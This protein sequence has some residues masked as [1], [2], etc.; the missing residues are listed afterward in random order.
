[1]TLDFGRCRLSLAV[2]EDFAYAG[3]GVTAGRRIA[4]TLSAHAA[5]LPG[6]AWHHGRDRD[7]VRRGRDRATARPRR[8][9]LRPG[10][11]RQHAAANHLREVET[12]L[13]SQAVLIRT[14]VPVAAQKLDWIDRLLKRIDGVQQVRESKYIMLHAP[15]S[16]LAEITQPAAR[17]RA[18]DHHPARGHGREGRGARRLP[19]ERV[20]GDA[21]EPE[22]RRRVCDPGPAGREDAGMNATSLSDLRLE[23]L[24]APSARGTAAPA[25][26]A[27]PAGDCWTASATIIDAGSRATVTPR[28]S[29]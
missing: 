23:P 24:D 20:L 25:G 11:D 13:E 6:D 27:R 28:C 18:P 22:G 16:A 2:P 10:F 14:P 5:P 29:S 1:M 12:V 7:A 3:T 4:T 17:Q 19:R 15:R 9:D 21:R 26:A 8:P